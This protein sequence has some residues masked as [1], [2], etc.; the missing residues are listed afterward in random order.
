MRRQKSEAGS[1]KSEVPPQLSYEL[2]R[3]VSFSQVL[4]LHMIINAVHEL[5]MTRDLPHILVLSLFWFMFVISR[6]VTYFIIN[7]AFLTGYGPRT[8]NQ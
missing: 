2:S 6:A 5:S 3:K 7:L 8:L 4:G 1:R